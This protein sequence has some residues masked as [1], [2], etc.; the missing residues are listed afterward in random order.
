MIKTQLFKEVIL[1]DIGSKIRAARIAKNMTQEELGEILGVQRSA[2]AKYENNRV[3]NIKRSTLKKISEVL[4][5]PPFELIYNGDIEEKAA[6]IDSSGMSE[7]KRNLR[8]LVDSCSDEEAS[9]LLQMMELFL[10][11]K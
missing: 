5:I 2:V 11:K 4:D 9:R 7:V 1:M 6:T 3:V 10:Q 8:T